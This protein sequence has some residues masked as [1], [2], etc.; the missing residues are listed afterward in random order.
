MWGE[1]TEV[2]PDRRSLGLMGPFASSGHKRWNRLGGV[3][4]GMC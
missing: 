4:F 1:G 3:L 2:L